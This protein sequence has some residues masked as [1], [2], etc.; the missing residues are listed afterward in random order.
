VTTIAAASSSHYAQGHAAV[1]ASSAVALD[2][3]FQTALYVLTGLL[4]TGAII[5]VALV[6]SAAAPSAKARPVDGE[7][8]ALEEA[9]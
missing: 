5:A 4:V 3:G 8:F 7:V 2:H 6:K 9:A 1:T